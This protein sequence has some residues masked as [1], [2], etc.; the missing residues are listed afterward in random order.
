MT[1]RSTISSSGSTISSARGRRRGRGRGG[2]G[3]AAARG[4]GGLLGG[5]RRG[6]VRRRVHD[7]GDQRDRDAVPGGRHFLEPGVGVGDVLVRTLHGQ[8]QE[9]HGGGSAAG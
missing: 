6:G 2:R 8:L 3:G 9:G 5:V 4:G 1:R 7:R